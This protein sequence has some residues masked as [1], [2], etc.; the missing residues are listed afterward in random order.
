MLKPGMRVEE[1]TKKVGQVP[2]YGKVVAV[3]GE[4][5]EVRWED[6]HTSIVS[7][8]SLHAIKADSSA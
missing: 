8:Q 1:L 2:R 3:H 6:E 7:R 5:V 4:S